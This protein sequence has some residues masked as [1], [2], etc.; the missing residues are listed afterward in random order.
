[1]RVA[2]AIGEGRIGQVVEDG[3]GGGGEDQAAGAAHHI[4]DE[5]DGKVEA[6]FV[7]Q[8][9]EGIGERGEMLAELQEVGHFGLRHR[10]FESAR[11]ERFDVVA[12]HFLG[13]AV[14]KSRTRGEYLLAVGFQRLTFERTPAYEGPAG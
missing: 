2:G 11:L 3:R 12:D 13:F 8:G 7:A 10:E 14:G 9:V 1:M 5:Q 6:A 4:R